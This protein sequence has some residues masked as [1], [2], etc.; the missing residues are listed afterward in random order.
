MFSAIKAGCMNIKQLHHKRGAMDIHYAVIYGQK[1][2]FLWCLEKTQQPV[3]F[4]FL[5]KSAAADGYKDIL[6]LCHECGDIIEKSFRCSC[7][8]WTR[9]G[10]DVCRDLGTV[11]SQQALEDA[12]WGENM[13]IITKIKGMGIEPTDMAMIGAACNGNIQAMKLSYTWG[14]KIMPQH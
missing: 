5:A 13:T 7:Y 6:T 1:E 11:P 4:K 8:E 14:H 12:V 2:I 10:V 3:D 9:K